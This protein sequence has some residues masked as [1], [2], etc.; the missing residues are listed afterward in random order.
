[1]GV[2]KFSPYFEVKPWL[3]TLGCCWWG[4]PVE[5]KKVDA[6]SISMLGT[7][8]VCGSPASRVSPGIGFELGAGVGY[9]FSSSG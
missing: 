6:S 8:A 2:E 9:G 3:H 1:M 7:M 4:S 5:E